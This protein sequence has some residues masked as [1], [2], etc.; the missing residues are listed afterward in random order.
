MQTVSSTCSEHFRIQ[1]W[2]EYDREKDVVLTKENYICLSTNCLFYNYEEQALLSESVLLPSIR[3][4]KLTLQFDIEGNEAHV[5]EV[6]PYHIIPLSLITKFFQLWQ[7]NESEDTRQTYSNG[8]VFTLIGRLR[9]SLRKLLMVQMKNMNAFSDED[10]HN[11]AV[12]VQ[13]NENDTFFA[14]MFGRAHSW[15]NGNI[16]L[17]PRNRGPFHPEFQKNE[18][19]LLRAFE[20]DSEPI[21]G[22][23]HYEE[24][25]LLHSELIRFV[26]EAPEMTLL[27]KLLKGFDI[28]YTTTFVLVRYDMTRMDI[29]KWELREPTDDELLEVRT[30]QLRREMRTE[31][32]WDIKKQP[33]RFS[34][35]ADH[36]YETAQGLQRTIPATK[37]ELKYLWSEFLLD[38]MKISINDRIQGE[39]F[40]WSYN[41]SR[42]Y[43][44]FLFR[45]SDTADTSTCASFD[46]Y[47]YSKISSSDDWISCNNEKPLQSASKWFLAW[48]RI[49]SKSCVEFILIVEKSKGFCNYRIPPSKSYFSDVE[50]LMQWL[51]SKISLTECKKKKVHQLILPLNHY[52]PLQKTGSVVEI[53]LCYMT[54]LI[55]ALSSANDCYNAFK[56][57]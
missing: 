43:E 45:M 47:L 37:D 16:F 54:T 3:R 29:E 13:T 20:F 30:A 12:N 35:S 56:K 15:L 51:S 7:S 52:Q 46:E 33:R 28:Y 5:H 48:R 18:E 17:G 23:Q 31:R 40:T 53:G 44:D 26:S 21:I 24:S 14:E 41:L 57:Q 10:R 19:E 1:I 25:F 38:I 39:S 49:M 32:Y 27:D 6:T 55:T 36:L 22:S 2:Y 4:P 50:T 8:C 34:R 11:I 42:L 9:R